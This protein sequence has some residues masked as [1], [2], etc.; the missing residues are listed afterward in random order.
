MS[1]SING[2][3]IFNAS[4][5]R[6]LTQ[7][8]AR[9]DSLSLQLATGQKSQD[10]AGLGNDRTIALS[11]RGKLSAVDSYQSNLTQVS[12]RTNLMM[13][14]LTGLV[15]I[16]ADTRGDLD[17]NNYLLAGS[18]T[19]AQSAA[20]TRF[21]TAVEALNVDVAGV[22]LFGGRDVD[23]RP[24]ASASEIFDGTVGRDGLLTV[25]QQRRAADLGADGRGRL[26]QAT[27]AGATVTLAE[28]AAVNAF[29]FKLGAVSTNQP[30]AFGVTSA[31]GSPP[32]ITVQVMG[33]PKPGDVVRVALTLPD[34][35]TEEIKLTASNNPPAPELVA[36]ANGSQLPVG[37]LGTTALNDPMVGLVAGD[38]LTINGQTISVVAGVPGAG[39]ISTTATVDDLMTQIEGLTGVANA[40]LD[41]ATR[42]VRI[43]STN[44]TDLAITGTVGA[45][46]GINGT[47]KAEELEKHTFQI[48]Y[49]GAGTVDLNATAQ[50]FASA[51]DGAVKKQATTSL[52][53]ASSVQGSRDFFGEPPQRVGSMPPETATT[54]VDGTAT[55]VD[56]Y[57]G[58]SGAGSARLTQVARI[59]STLTANYGARANEDGIREFMENLG[60]FA[61]MELDSNST[62][63]KKQY[64]E[65]IERTRP[66]MAEDGGAAS[67]RAVATDITQVAAFSQAA[68]ERHKTQKATLETMLANVEGISKEEVAANILA[69]QTNLQASYQT[70]AIISQLS[71]VNFL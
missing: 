54:L 5:S 11:V 29:G 40:E 43:T 23:S 39:Q 1:S 22:Y 31:S 47:V 13:T 38:T 55:T 64:G 30:G 63:G 3:G 60:A 62:L 14:S 51:L 7:M 20:R 69:L 49:T 16:A 61:A 41:P 17:P 12:L 42:Q 32:Q 44:G 6:A 28:S 56:W 48:A 26:T 58:E 19:L 66:A 34:G 50:N 4:Y 27:A 24:V 10:Y 35:S 18:K 71:L 70:T 21:D 8:R 2:T 33:T 15:D 53:A 37:T 52:A 67:L 46:L 57:K 9:L 45:K 68:G 59:D 65:L 25:I 36:Q